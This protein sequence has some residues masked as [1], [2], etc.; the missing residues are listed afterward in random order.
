MINLWYDI[1]I[2]L[3]EDL[4]LVHFTAAPL[5]I[6]KAANFGFGRPFSHTLDSSPARY[7]MR[8]RYA[9]LFG[10]NGHYQ[11]SEKESIQ[12]IRAYAQSEPLTVK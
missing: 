11:Y 10:G 4:K 12:A 8:T 9:E 7:D 2:A 3:R 6:S 5:S 1:Q